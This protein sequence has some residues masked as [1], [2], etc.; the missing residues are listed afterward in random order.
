MA[1]LRQFNFL[2]RLNLAQLGLEFWLPLPLIAAGIWAGSQW[3]NDRVLSQ[4]YTTTA[5][6]AAEQQQQVNIVLALTILSID[7]EIDRRGGTAEVTVQT[8]GSALKE[9]EFEYPVTEFAELEQAI[10]QELSL[11]PDQVRSLIRYRID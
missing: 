11:A 5:Q 3:L 4:T 6:L 7:A 9:L 10:A 8:A 2:A 1:R